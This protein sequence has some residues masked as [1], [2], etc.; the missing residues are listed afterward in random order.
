MFKR[1]EKGLLE[2]WEEG[3]RTIGTGLEGRENPQKD[4]KRSRRMGRWLE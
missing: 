4:G 1:T 3:I 2:G